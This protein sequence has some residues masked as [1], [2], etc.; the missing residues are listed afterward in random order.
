MTQAIFSILS[1]EYPCPLLLLA[2]PSREHIDRYTHDST[3][4]GLI[5]DG[6][7]LAEFWKI[8]SLRFV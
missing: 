1:D 6:V 7:T 4:I 2:D 8:T 5:N 3:V